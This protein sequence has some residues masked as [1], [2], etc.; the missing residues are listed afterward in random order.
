M[1]IARTTAL[2][3]AAAAVASLL[4]LGAASAAQAVT[5]TGSSTAEYTNDPT[6]TLDFANAT[7]GDIVTIN[8]VST[9]PTVYGQVTVDS[10]GAGSVT[11]VAPLPTRSQQVVELREYHPGDLVHPVN[12]DAEYLYTDLVPQLD[13]GSVHDGDTVDASAVSFDAQTDVPSGG[14]INGWRIALN[15]AQEGGAATAS[16]EQTVNGSGGV[17]GLA[18]AQPLAAG[19]YTATATTIDTSSERNHVDANLPSDPSNPVSFF[20][21]PAQPTVTGLGGQAAHEGENLNQSAPT[22]TVSGVLAGAQVKLFTYDPNTGQP[23]LVGLGTAAGAGQLTIQTTGLSDGGVRLWATQTVDENGTPVSSDGSTDPHSPTSTPSSTFDVNVDTAAPALSGG[24]TDGA[25]TNQARPWFRV[26]DGPGGGPAAGPGAEFV[27]RAHGATV[28]DSRPVATDAYGAATWVPSADLPEGTYTAS[29]VTV[30]DS[31]NVNSG[32]PSN[33]ITFTVDTTAPNAPTVLS[34]AD[35]AT[36]STS[37]PTITVAAEP[38][39]QVTLA[40]DADQYQQTADAGGIATFTPNGPLS[41][42]Q[43]FLAALATDSA[44]NQGSTTLTT[45]TVSTA[46]GT[47]PQPPVQ[48]TPGSAAARAATS[49]SAAP[50]A[51]AADAPADPGHLGAA[52]AQLAH[53]DRRPPAQGRGQADRPRHGHAATD[54]EGSGQDE[55]HRHCHRQGADRNRPLHAHPEVRR[56]HARQGR[57]H[58][59]AQGR[60]RQERDGRTERPLSRAS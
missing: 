21:A 41:D 38:G 55:G 10:S 1:T 48:A 42:G 5:I 50:D 37:Q 54:H 57:L 52:G 18:P 24:L 58:A 4:S 27:I 29:V 47:T 31:G 13:S 32:A 45:F 12:G 16:A 22:V 26:N 17:N 34:P 60:R 28:V 56:A 51:A 33:A 3:I 35:G 14:F 46:G 36:V 59:H 9:L 15:V 39:S 49:G 11:V 23:M 53:A 43:H 44:G 40:V 6:P 25:V 30:D 2:A 19:Q 8:A 7:P 20:V